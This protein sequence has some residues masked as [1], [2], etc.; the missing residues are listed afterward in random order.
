MKDASFSLT[1]IL[2]GV[3]LVLLLALLLVSLKQVAYSQ[4]TLAVVEGSSMYPLLREGDLV[5]AY[6]PP[7]AHIR[8]GDIIIYRVFNKLIIHRVIDVK[9]VN[10][11]YYYVTQGDNNP[12]PDFIYFDV[13][14]GEPVGVSYNR[15]IGVVFSVD[16]ST[17]KIPYIGYLAIWYHK[18]T[19]T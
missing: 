11:D 14:N 2:V 8:V 18:L 10:G 5:F 16:G 17:L 7:P 9:I 1:K 12:I 13:V 19:G 3:L 15:V 4:P 6:R